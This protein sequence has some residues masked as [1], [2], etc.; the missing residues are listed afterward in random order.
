MVPE[1]LVLGSAAEVLSTHRAAIVAS[2]DRAAIVTSAH[3][4]KMSAA[5]P[6]AVASTGAATR[7]RIGR[8]ASTSHRYRGNNDRNPVQRKFLHGSFLSS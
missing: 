7:K 5:E 6:T 8:N 4:A 1:M 3:P 2:T